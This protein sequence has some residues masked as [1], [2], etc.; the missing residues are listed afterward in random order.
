MCFAPP[1]R[2][3]TGITAATSSFSRR[4]PGNMPGPP[5]VSPFR[6]RATSSYHAPPRE[7]VEEQMRRYVEDIRRR[8]PPPAGISIP[9]SH[10]PRRDSKGGK[11]I[12]PAKELGG[13]H[14]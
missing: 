10:S 14:S 13:L 12:T 11:K 4:L 7:V 9:A 3:R 1:R 2:R 8:Q 5:S 6:R